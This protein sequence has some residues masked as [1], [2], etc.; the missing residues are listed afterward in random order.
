M[1]DDIKNLH[2]QQESYGDWALFFYDPYGGSTIGVVWKPGSQ[3]PR[4]FKVTHLA[5]RRWNRKT[6]TLHLDTD[7]LMEGFHTLGGGLVKS[8]QVKKDGKFVSVHF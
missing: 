5:G 2:F 3:M 6:N 4:E 7:A 1:Y 8:V